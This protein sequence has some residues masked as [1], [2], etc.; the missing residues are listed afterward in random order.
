[1]RYETRS[2]RYEA[3]RRGPPLGAGMF[4]DRTIRGSSRFLVEFP[5]EHY[6]LYAHTQEVPEAHV[7]HGARL[8]KVIWAHNGAYKHQKQRGNKDRN[9]LQYMA[10]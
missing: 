5:L 7:G 1:M 3:Q 9:R 10:C 6:E 2:T 4:V 8:A